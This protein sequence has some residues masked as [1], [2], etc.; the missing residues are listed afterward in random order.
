MRVGL[1]QLTVIDDPA[2][3]LP[4]TVDFV[5]QAAAGGAGFVL[6]PELTNG[7]SS[8]RCLPA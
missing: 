2:A 1:V 7:L 8:A 5:R 4:V 3:N 6:T